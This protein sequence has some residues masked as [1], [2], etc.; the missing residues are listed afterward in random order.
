[1][2]DPNP[3]LSSGYKIVVVKASCLG[4][5]FWQDDIHLKAEC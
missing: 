4:Y 5:S 2:Q 1:M 3:L